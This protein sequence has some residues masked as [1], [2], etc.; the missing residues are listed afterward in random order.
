MERPLISAIIIFLNEECFLE[1]AIASVL[2]QTYENWELLLVDDGSTDG[3]RA[4]AM[5]YAEQYPDKI[6]CL[7]HPGHENCGMS[8]SLALG[9]HHSQ[10]EYVAYLDGDDVW[11]PE[12]LSRQL[13]LLFHHP[14]AVL[15][16][17]PLMQWYSWTGKPEDQSRDRRRGGQ[18]PY[19]NTVVQAPHLL[20]L[21][22]ENEDFIP[23]GFLIR[24]DVLQEGTI[25]EPAFRGNFSDAV[26]LV[27]I[28]LTSAVYVA[29]ESWY[30]YRRHPDSWTYR[31]WVSGEENATRLRYLNWVEDYFDQQNITD[32]RLLKVLRKKQWRCHHPKLSQWLSLKDQL[33]QLE[34]L[35]IRIGRNILPL[36]LRNWLW[37]YWEKLRYRAL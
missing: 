37:R 26:A 20:A 11:L 29:A 7:A 2:Q 33:D 14:E 10:G 18:H 12:K 28:C 13:E 30:L 5:D 8:A 15:V 31:T 17:G 22:L 32:R 36:T 35:V 9:I 23:S 6:R 3:S 25:Y 16:H 21:F 19:C 34:Q 27:K 4:I 1:G 24:K